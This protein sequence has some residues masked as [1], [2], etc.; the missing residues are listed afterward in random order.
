MFDM[1][2]ARL[3]PGEDIVG[4][5]GMHGIGCLDGGFVFA[6]FA[7]THQKRSAVRLDRI[8]AFFFAI[9]LHEGAIAETDG[10]FAGD[11]RDLVAGS[12]KS[13]IYH[14]D[15]ARVAGFD[16]DHSGIGTVE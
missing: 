3:F 1:A 9:P 4:Y 7:T 16:A 10:P 13:A 14:P 8:T 2:G 15:A 6:E 5:D 11:F 12:P